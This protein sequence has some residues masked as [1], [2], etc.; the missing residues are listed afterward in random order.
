MHA[1]TVM[2]NMKNKHSLIQK[3]SVEFQLETE[4]LRGGLNT[5]YP[6]HFSVYGI[7]IVQDG[8]PDTSL[9]W[10]SS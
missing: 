6:I 5:L 8:E 4:M 9:T 3:P 2:E 10:R 1:L 7:L